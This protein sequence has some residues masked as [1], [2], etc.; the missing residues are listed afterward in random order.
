MSKNKSKSSNFATYCFAVASIALLAIGWWQ[1]DEYW[2]T[3]E[4]GWGYAF[5][6]IGGSLMLLL[7]LYPVRKKIKL[8]R[9]WFNIRHWFRLH[10]VFGIIG[11]ILILFHSNFH[12][13][14]L[15]SS[16]ALF[17]MLLVAGSGL[18][19]RYVY[20]QIHRGL[21]GE[22]IQFDE[23]KEDYT[24]S[25]EHFLGSELVHPATAAKLEKVES[26]LT[27]RQITLMQSWLANYTVS[28]LRR[29]IK[30]QIKKNIKTKKFTKQQ[31]NELKLAYVNWNQGINNLL[32]MSKFAFNSNLF[33]LWHVLHLPF[34][35]MMII[36]AIIHIVVVHMY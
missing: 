19:G 5:G 12:L 24:K 33:S 15:N 35:F 25:R 3:P 9:N 6:I 23:L 10:M 2:F 16:I 14:S 11:P 20:Q 30:K 29:K 4:R 17:C 28:G 13:G 1:R 31:A 34:F 32:R 18:V 21:Y 7:L 36:A 27:N 22:L 26:L 8:M